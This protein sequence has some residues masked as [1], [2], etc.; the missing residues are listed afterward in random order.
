MKKAQVTQINSTTYR[1]TEKPLGEAVY[2]YLLIGAEKALLIDTGYGLTDIPS[3]VQKITNLP[4]LVVNTHGHM[5]HIHGN[6]FYK[7]VYLAKED[8]EVFLRH[9]NR[10]YLTGLLKDI[11]RENGLPLWIM[12][13]P[14]LRGLVKKI[15]TAYPSSHKP[16]PENNYFELGNRRVDIVHT[17]GHTIGSISLLDQRNGWLFSGDTTC[18]KGVLLHFPES[19]DVETFRNSLKKLKILADEGKI[20]KLFPAH[21]ETPLEP[22]QLDIFLEACDLLMKSKETQNKNRFC[23]KG[24]TIQY[25]ENKI[26]GAL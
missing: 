9:A 7:E 20:R 14:I 17:P 8:E 24:F 25:E 1:F 23:H 19:T 6:R 16:L 13:L 4:V 12:K 11:L 2:M 15:V 18:R 5:D 22:E 10:E 21:Q 26:G 3:A